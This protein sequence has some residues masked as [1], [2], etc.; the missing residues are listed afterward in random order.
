[1]PAWS[2]L[3]ASDG[4]TSSTGGSFSKAMGSA[5][6]LRLVARLSASASVNW[7]V[8]WALPSRIRPFMVGAEMTWPSRTM[9]KCFSVLTSA[10]EISAKV[11]GALAVE[12]EVDAPLDALLSGVRVLAPARSVPSIMALDSRNLLA[13]LVAGDQRLVGVVDD[14]GGLRRR[15]GR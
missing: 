9:A 6:Y 2:W 1:M 3:P 12:V 7:P 14:L 15:S 4:P 13:E 11:L 5:P 8:I 10:R